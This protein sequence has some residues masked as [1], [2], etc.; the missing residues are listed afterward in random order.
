MAGMRSSFR[1]TLATI[2]L[3][4]SSIDS[5]GQPELKSASASAGGRRK[6]A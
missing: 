4:R 5:L 1:Y 3:S 2:T 6:T